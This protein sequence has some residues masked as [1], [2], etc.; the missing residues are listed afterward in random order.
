MEASFGL[1]DV[2]PSSRPVIKVLLLIF[3]SDVG[4]D[5][6]GGRLSLV[7]S[8]DPAVALHPRECVISASSR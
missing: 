8:P 3:E 5:E 7:P 6:N 1:R 4:H 2:T